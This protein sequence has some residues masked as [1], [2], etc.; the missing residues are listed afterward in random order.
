MWSALW[1][2]FKLL[3]FH[4]CNEIKFTDIV[5]ERKSRF[6]S[7]YFVGNMIFYFLPILCFPPSVTMLSSYWNRPSFVL[8]DSANSL[9]SL[10]SHAE[11]SHI[12]LSSQFA[13]TQNSLSNY[14]FTFSHNVCPLYLIISIQLK[15]G[16]RQS[17]YFSTYLCVGFDIW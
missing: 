15:W 14:L 4:T 6:G 5:K 11:Q 1:W 9:L 3:R 7:P 8:A 16:A 12:S 10:C 2:L 17:R 13:L